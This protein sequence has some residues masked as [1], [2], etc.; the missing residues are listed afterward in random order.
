MRV[1]RLSGA[2]H[3]D[4]LSGKGAELYGGRWNIK[5]L[6]M[7]YAASSQAICVVEILVHTPAGNL[8]KGYRMIELDIPDTSVKI[9]KIKELPHN[10][11]RYSPAPA[12]QA[13]GDEFLR[14]ARHLCLKVPAT[15]VQGDHNLLINPRHPLFSKVKRV[16][17]EN[18]TFD[19]QL[20]LKDFI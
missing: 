12:T 1:F 5:G 14:K 4:D 19:D 8:P 17:S 20:A 11:N 15:A 18:F 7:L 3:G 2:Q 13:I 10:W 9:L 6:P 16:K